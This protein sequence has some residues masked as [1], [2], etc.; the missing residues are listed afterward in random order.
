MIFCVTKNTLFNIILLKLL[1]LKYTLYNWNYEI[2]ILSVVTKKIY[3]Y[4]FYK[5]NYICIF[6]LFV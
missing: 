3:I 2:I 1:K 4:M 5:I 6:L